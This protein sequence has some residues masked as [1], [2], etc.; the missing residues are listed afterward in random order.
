VVSQHDGVSWYV[1]F[2]QEAKS[3]QLLIELTYQEPFPETC[4]KIDKCLEAQCENGVALSL[5]TVQAIMVAYIKHDVPELF[6]KTFPDG[7]KFRCSESFVRKLDS[8]TQQGYTSTV[9]MRHQALSVSMIKRKN[10]WI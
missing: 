3:I 8:D 6:T 5:V 7:S 10:D 9:Y 1:I 2:I 4:T